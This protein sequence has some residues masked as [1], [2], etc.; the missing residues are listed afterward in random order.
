M[1][2]NDQFEPKNTMKAA[3]SVEQQLCQRPVPIVAVHSRVTLESV[4]SLSKCAC[5]YSATHWI[6]EQIRFWLEFGAKT[7]VSLDYFRCFDCQTI[8]RHF[9]WVWICCSKIGYVLLRC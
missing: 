6:R 8:H 3:L 4:F 1:E 5:M 2:I 7:R 9:E